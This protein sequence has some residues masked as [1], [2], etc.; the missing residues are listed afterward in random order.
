MCKDIAKRQKRN[1]IS[2]DGHQLK[3]VEEYKYFWMKLLTSGN[4]MT[5]KRL[6]IG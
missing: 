1:G 4:E 3:E 6:R 2:V 5:I